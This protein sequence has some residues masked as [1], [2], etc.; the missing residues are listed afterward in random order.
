MHKTARSLYVITG[1]IASSYT[2]PIGEGSK[3]LDAF[4]TDPRQ[5]IC[6]EL[7]TRAQ[8]HVKRESLGI[9]LRAPDNPY[10]AKIKVKLQGTKIYLQKLE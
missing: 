1:V 7:E 5:L 8:A 4:L 6:I 9:Q 3:V 10:S 2:R